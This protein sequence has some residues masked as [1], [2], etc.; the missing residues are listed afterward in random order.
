[1]QVSTSI[2]DIEPI[3]QGESKTFEF[4]LE[5]EDGDRIDLSGSI[6]NII[7][8]FVSGSTFVTKRLS[9]APQVVIKS[10]AVL[11]IIEVILSQ[12]D[13]TSLPPVEDGTIEIVVEFDS[14][15]VGITQLNDAFC[16]IASIGTPN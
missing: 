2:K 12:E 11:G 10:P 9:D 15:N 4:V 16:V 7:V 14:F 13:T 3:Y 1:M 8:E 5:D 6:Q